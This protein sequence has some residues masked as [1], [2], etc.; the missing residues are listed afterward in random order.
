MLMTLEMGKPLAEAGA[1]SSTAPSSSAGSAEEAVRIH[2]RYAA[3]PAGQHPAG[4]DAPTGRA[5]R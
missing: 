4:H 1:R 5:R 2:G 3:N